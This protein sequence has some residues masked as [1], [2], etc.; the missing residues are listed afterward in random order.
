[1]ARKPKLRDVEERVKQVDLDLWEIDRKS[2]PELIQHLKDIER[3]AEKAGYTCIFL[4]VD[5]SWEHTYLE[6]WGSR[7]E[8][9]QEARKRLDKAK[10][11]RERKKRAKA[12]KEEKERA[13]LA[14][15]KKKYE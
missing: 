1:M 10:A 8:T 12:T 14:R 2:F 7:K 15:L 4:V 3:E 5:Q 9:E 13:E 11:E 6:V